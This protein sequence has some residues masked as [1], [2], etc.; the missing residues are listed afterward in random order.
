M[1][2]LWFLVL[3]GEVGMTRGFSRICLAAGWMALLAMGL[4][5]PV[6]SRADVLAK[7]DRLPPR[8]VRSIVLG[9]PALARGVSGVYETVSGPVEVVIR[10]G[11]IVLK[12]GYP[13]LPG[14]SGP[15]ERRCPVELRDGDEVQVVRDQDLL[16]ICL[17]GIE[18]VFVEVR[19]DDWVR[20]EWSGEAGSLTQI[21]FQKMG[22]IC[23]DDDFMHEDASLGPW[24]PERGLWKVNALDNPVRSAN[25]FSFKGSG[26]QA[27]AVAGEWFWTGY[28]FSSSVRPLGD[29]ALAWHF[30]RHGDRTGYCLLWDQGR[31]S[32]KK[33]VSGHENELGAVPMSRLAGQ[34]YRVEVQAFYGQLGVKIDGVPVLVAGDDSPILSGRIGLECDGESGAIYDDVEVRSVNS[35][36][37]RPGGGARQ[38]PAAFASW[39]GMKGDNSQKPVEIPAS[40][41]VFAGLWRTNGCIETEL[42]GPVTPG[43]LV[44]GLRVQPNSGLPAGTGVDGLFLACSLDTARLFLR[45]QGRE[46]NLACFG[47]PG[48]KAGS[49]IGLHCFGDEIWASLDG[50]RLGGVRQVL[51]IAKGNSGVAFPA[52]SPPAVVRLLPEEPLPLVSNRI[53]T[54]S[55][56]ADAMTAWAAPLG[57]WEGNPH[58]GCSGF[59]VHRSDFWRDVVVALET[60]RLPKGAFGKPFGLAMVDP[61]QEGVGSVATWLRVEPLADGRYSLGLDLG[62]RTVRRQALAGLPESVSLGRRLGRLLVWVDGVVIWDEPL[63]EALAGL[64]QVARFGEGSLPKWGEALAVSAD[65]VRT[66]SFATAPV[67]WQVAG[68]DWAVTNRWQCDPRWSF[69]SGANRTGVAC[70]WNKLALAGDGTLEYFAAPK[71]DATRGGVEYWYASDLN[72]VLG[73]SGADIEGGLAL[74]LAGRRNAGSFLLQGRHELAANETELAKLPLDGGLHHRWSHV[75]I[76]IVGRSVQVWIDGKP[77]LKS[78][79]AAPLAGDRFGLWTYRNAIMVSQVRISAARPWRPATG[80]FCPFNQA[81]RTPYDPVPA[82]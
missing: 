2:V 9:P 19:G 14:E 7:G 72:A 13:L 79:L 41:W 26:G 56:E 71:M 44:L 69:F 30:C 60:S 40:G 57:E 16:S 10:P 1:A 23:F 31:L 25:A 39:S 66:Y 82:K 68:G 61:L 5:L 37:W 55:R 49:K 58:W 62:N 52:V 81:P 63:P 6:F 33:R 45:K 34:W 64:C 11:C 53:E 46:E 38:Y 20:E 29:G 54:F 8:F 36:E 22:T 47:L 59:F 32:L 51:S 15:S 65:N 24:K 17:N 28:R 35:L 74:L 78:L 43:C 12:R 42:Q 73:A 21:V 50:C 80:L 77:V 4:F 18:T 76:R 75:K 70:L 27:L 3:V 48:M 67:D